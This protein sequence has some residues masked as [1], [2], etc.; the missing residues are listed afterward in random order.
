MW[1]QLYKVVLILDYKLCPPTH[2]HAHTH[3]H[4]HTQKKTIVKQLSPIMVIVVMK[5]LC[6]NRDLKYRLK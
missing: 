5:T 4:I 3:T 2:T 6:Q 1:A